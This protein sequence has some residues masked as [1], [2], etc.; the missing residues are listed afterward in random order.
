MHV[1]CSTQIISQNKAH[2]GHQNP[3]NTLLPQ[4]PFIPCIAWHAG[5][6]NFHAWVTFMGGGRYK[7]N[8][9]NNSESVGAEV[10]R[11]LLSSSIPMPG[12]CH[13]SQATTL[14]CAAHGGQKHAM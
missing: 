3:S 8:G 1:R 6:R 11:W 10:R 9:F 13:S 5:I 7:A 2:S 12:D 4:L 14:F